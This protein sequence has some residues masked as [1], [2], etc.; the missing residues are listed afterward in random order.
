VAIGSGSL[1]A[2]VPDQSWSSSVALAPAAGSSGLVSAIRD[3]KLWN[4]ARSVAEVVG[5]MTLTPS[6]TDP[7]LVAWYS[8]AANQQQPLILVEQDTFTT[9]T[10]GWQLA[11]G[12]TPPLVAQNNA[13]N[14]WSGFLGP[15]AAQP[16]PTN[17]TNGQA[18]SRAYSLNGKGGLVTADLYRLGGGW[19]NQSL[20]VYLNNSEIISLS[21][22]SSTDYSTPISGSSPISGSNS[23]YKLSVR[24]VADYGPNWG[25]GNSQSFQLAIDVPEGIENLTLGFG[26]NLA[27]PSTVAAYGIESVEV[28]QFQA[29]AVLSGG[30]STMADASGGVD[31]NGNPLYAGVANGRFTSTICASVRSVRGSAAVQSAHR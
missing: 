6:G 5:D 17:Q 26:S 10:E 31:A 16:N 18:V 25:S 24:P 4:G 8:F 12:G 29:A 9:S 20:A 3:L 15:F 22:N 7:G 28:Y 27:V 14:D 11:G 2:P 19:Q 21:L 23:G 1:G 13:S 30:A